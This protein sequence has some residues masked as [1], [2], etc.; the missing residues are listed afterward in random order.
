M[1]GRGWRTPS[2]PGHLEACGRLRTPYEA[3]PYELSPETAQQYREA[4]ANLREAERL[5]RALDSG[6]CG[7]LKGQMLARV[8]EAIAEAEGFGRF[9]LLAGKP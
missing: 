2:P 7:H 1:R 6:F 5:L 3:E 4:V 8:R 9:V